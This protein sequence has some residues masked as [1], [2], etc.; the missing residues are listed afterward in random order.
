MRGPNLTRMVAPRRAASSVPQPPP[1]PPRPVR[2]KGFALYG[3]LPLSSEIKDD[4]HWAQL[5]TQNK[6]WADVPLA[7]GRETGSR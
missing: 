1:P 2:G 4:M 6:N 3:P 5:Q 7:S